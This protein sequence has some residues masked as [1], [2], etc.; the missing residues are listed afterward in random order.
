[1]INKEKIYYYEL[2][3]VLSHYGPSNMG[4]HFISFC[5]NS[6]DGN[7]YKFNDSM[8]EESNFNEVSSSG[9]PYVLF[10]SYITI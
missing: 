8:V 2:V 4:G 3:G 7:W 5:K 9:M 10:Y 6:E 1:M